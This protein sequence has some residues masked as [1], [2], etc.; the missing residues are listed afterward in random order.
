MKNSK[1]IFP[2]FNRV[3]VEKLKFDLLYI[4]VW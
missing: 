4:I 2:F 1:N 3:E